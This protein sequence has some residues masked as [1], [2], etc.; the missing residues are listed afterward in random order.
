MELIRASK[1]IIITS[2][3]HVIKFVLE[4]F[5]KKLMFASQLHQVHV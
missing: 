5:I 4:K 3:E 1:Q 2:K